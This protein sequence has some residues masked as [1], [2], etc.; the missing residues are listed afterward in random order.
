MVFGAVNKKSLSA[1][2]DNS[3]PYPE[4]FLPPK[5]QSYI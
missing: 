2:R 5:R 3:T 1:Y 4:F